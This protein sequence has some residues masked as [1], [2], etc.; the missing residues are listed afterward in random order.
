MTRIVR[1]NHEPIDLAPI[2]REFTT[3]ECGAVTTF[4]GVV[5][6]H[7]G[8]RRV[9]AIEYSAYAGMAEQELERVVDRVAGNHGVESVA[10]VH[11]LGRL[12]VGESS[13]G[14]VVAAGHRREALMCCLELI[15]ELK[16]TVPIWK[17]EFGPDGSQWS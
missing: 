14:V 7:S 13:L 5:R 16:K 1:I 3:P 17:L 9:E 8:S 10:S 12:Q 6:D 4:L 11:R 15:D 2:V